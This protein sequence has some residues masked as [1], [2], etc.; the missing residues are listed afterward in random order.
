VKEKIKIWGEES[1]FLSQVFLNCRGK[2]EWRVR[3]SSRRRR[4]RSRRRRGVE[5]RQAGRQACQQK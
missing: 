4:R 5:G 1:C 2:K 3:R